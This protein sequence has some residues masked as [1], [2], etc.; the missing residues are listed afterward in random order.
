MKRI[1]GLAAL[2]FVTGCYKVTYHHGTENMSPAQ[3]EIWHHRILFGIV[4]VPDVINGPELCPDGIEQVHT[5][6]S[7]VNGLA[8]YVAGTL[9][10]NLYNPATVEVWC[11]KGQAYRL[12]QNKEGVVVAVTPIDVGREN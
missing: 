4:E 10:A 3:H 9:V 11:K 7:A 8:Q 1:L 6:I 12:E 2:T 5:E